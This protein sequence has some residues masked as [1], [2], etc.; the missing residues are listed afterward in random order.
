LF[1]TRT[2]DNQTTPTPTPNKNSTQ[3]NSTQLNEEEEED[4]SA[5]EKKTS[6]KVLVAVDG[7][8]AATKAFHEALCFVKPEDLLLILSVINKSA[9]EDKISE[10]LQNY[11]TIA[12][13]RGVR[14]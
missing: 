5:E 12:Q 13:Q 7:S 4:M 1:A 9:D 8:A 2:S 3:P 11:A 6:K 14:K 10:T